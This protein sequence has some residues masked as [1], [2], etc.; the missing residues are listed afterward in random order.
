MAAPA[1][2]PWHRSCHL[3]RQE[4]RIGLLGFHCNPGLALPLQVK[5]GACDEGE[6]EIIG[7]LSAAGDCVLVHK[8]GE[9]AGCGSARVTVVCFVAAAL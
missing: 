5:V 9:L 3:P 8:I 1:T 6:E 2:P 7:E 4:A